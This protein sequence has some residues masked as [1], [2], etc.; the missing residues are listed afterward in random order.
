MG[1][2]KRRKILGESEQENQN[3]KAKWEKMK[4]LQK[5]YKNAHRFI[6]GYYNPLT[7]EIL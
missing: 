1:E 5:R 3:R 7:K 6:R 4:F 2:A